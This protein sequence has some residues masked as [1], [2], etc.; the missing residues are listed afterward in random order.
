MDACKPYAIHPCGKHVNETYYGECPNDVWPTPA[1]KNKC[2]PGYKTP[3]RKDKIYAKSAYYVRPIEKQ[4]Q[5]EIMTRGP[6]QAGFDVYEDFTSY[7]SGIYEHLAGEQ[8]GGHAVKII[9]WGEE[10]GKKYWII[11]NSW[12]TDWGEDHGYFRMIR[13]VND[14]NLESEIVGGIMDV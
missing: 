6:V 12:N 4:I 11:A 9:G 3:Y 2:Q 10:D 14:C 8:V 7:T 5:Y 13:G 1:C